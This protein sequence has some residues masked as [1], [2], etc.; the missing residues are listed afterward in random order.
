[1]QR[2]EMPVDVLFVGAGPACLAGA[3]HLKKLVAAHNEAID[4]GTKSGSRLEDPQIAVIEKGS[5]VGAHQ[6]S[7]AVLDPNALDELVPDWRSREDFPLERFVVREELA[8]LTATNAIPAPWVPPEMDNHGKPIISLGRFAKWLGTLAEAAGVMIFPEFAGV[9]LLWDGEQ[10]AGVRTGDKGIGKD[11]Q[12][13]DTFAPGMNLRAKVTI[14]GEGPRG[15]LSRRLIE[16]K[17]LDKS[18]VSGVGAAN[19]MAY[20]LGCKEILEL[21]EG[22]VKEGFVLHTVGWPLPTDMFGGSFMYA[23]GGDKVCIGLLVALDAKN[24]SLDVHYELQKLKTHPYIRNILGKGKVVKYGAKAVSIGGWSSVP[25]VWTDGAMLV[26]DSAAFFNTMRIKGIN[27]AMKSGMLAA[28]AAFEGLLKNDFS[29]NTLKVY[30]ERVMTSWIKKDM[31]GAKNMHANF[32]GGLPGG[33]VRTGFDW[34]FGPGAKTK[35]FP[36]D[37]EHMNTIKQQYGTDVLPEPEKIA[38]D[39]KYLVDKLTDVYM[40]GTKHAEQQP[41]HLKIVDTNICATKCLTEYGNPC[42]KFCPAQV[43]NMRPSEK[44]G[45]LE[46]EVEFSNCV[47]CK[48]CDIRDPYQIIT[49]VPPEGSNGPEYHDL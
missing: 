23:M 33:M 5:A 24:P 18:H 3:I 35:H 31:D 36:A 2:D 16:Q 38:Y 27:L 47:H 32:A 34:L 40:S 8:F 17:G 28:E 43:Y 4:A 39:G 48:T 20:E 11:G 14:L 29:A 25:Q 44:T 46:M 15:H 21:P 12:P 37:Y 49:W 45:R 6:L 30:G 10:V 13:K 9:E 42:T 26:G 7:G 1:M 19:P 22:T 41:A